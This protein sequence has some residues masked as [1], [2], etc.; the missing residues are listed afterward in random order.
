MLHSERHFG[1]NCNA[2]YK[3]ASLFSC[4]RRARLSHSDFESI[5]YYAI[6]DTLV[7]VLSGNYMKS[8]NG[9]LETVYTYDPVKFFLTGERFAQYLNGHILMPEY[10]T[11][12]KPPKCLDEDYVPIFS[13]ETQSWSLVKG[14]DLNL[15]KLHIT[16]VYADYDFSKTHPDE[17]LPYI[18]PINRSDYL[19]DP[20]LSNIMKLLSSFDKLEQLISSF[21]AGLQFAQRVFYLNSQ[22]GKL[23]QEYSNFLKSLKAGRIIRLNEQQY[24]YFLQVDILHNIKKLLD[25]VIVA[26][27]LRETKEEASLGIYFSLECDGLAYILKKDKSKLR[28]RIRETINFDYYEDLLTTINDLHNGYKHDVL[29]EQIH[30][31]VFIQPC[32]FLN[33]TSMIR[34]NG[35]RIKDLQN[36][37]QYRIDTRKLIFAFND[38]LSFILEGKENSKTRVQFKKVPENKFEWVR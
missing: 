14:E 15:K 20:N 2:S 29:T 9:K 26:L 30:S 4:N 8:S 32:F 28:D 13:V 37:I 17:A 23:Y 7:S 12:I 11:Q 25:T 31:E 34:R 36:V 24:F 21:S 18:Y 1:K 35:K 33:K 19:G 22:I 3:I 5:E 27:Y 16:F 38:F 10:S 6:N